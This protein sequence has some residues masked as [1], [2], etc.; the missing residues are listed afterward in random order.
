MVSLLFLMYLGC[1]WSKGSAL[2]S[3]IETTSYALCALAHVYDIAIGRADIL[4]LI[5]RGSNYLMN[6]RTSSGWYTTR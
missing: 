1:F 4:P 3:E 5:E 2:S 6:T